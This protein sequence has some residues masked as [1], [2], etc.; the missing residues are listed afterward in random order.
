[1]S[2]EAEPMDYPTL[3]VTT[4]RL[5][6]RPQDV[7]DEVGMDQRRFRRIRSGK[8]EVPPWL[9][10]QVRQ[11]ADEVDTDAALAAKD[12]SEQHRQSGQAVTLLRY[13]AKGFLQ[14]HEQGI[15]ARSVESWDAYLAL[16][17]FQLEEAGVPFEYATR[18]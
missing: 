10:A 4:A 6:F 1:M 8:Y 12:L 18:Q 3:A 16:I 9:D 14:R 2:D 5:G 7:A 17:S 15:K 11:W 13:P